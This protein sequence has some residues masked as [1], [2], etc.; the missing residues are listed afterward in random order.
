VVELHKQVWEI[1]CNLEVLHYKMQ[2]H[3]IYKL[4]KSK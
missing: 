4:L 2:E 3:L 1:I